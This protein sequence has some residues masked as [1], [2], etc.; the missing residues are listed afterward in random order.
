[1]IPFYATTDLIS[2]EDVN[3]LENLCKSSEAN[4]IEYDTVSG[5]KDGNLC[6]DMD[7]PYFK[8]FNYEC[9]TMF[10]HQ[11][12]NANVVAHVDNPKWKRNTV[13]IVPL[14][15]HKDYAP[16]HFIDGPTVTHEKPILFNT[17]LP[18]YINN[19]EYPRYNF[20]ICFEQP[21]EELVECLINI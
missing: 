15:W 18:H 17:Q 11:P 3:F 8:R 6:W 9:Y 12:A 19:N 5:K 4:F 10:V 13:L 1:M 2:L 16:C 21:I 7:L 20:Q 14:F